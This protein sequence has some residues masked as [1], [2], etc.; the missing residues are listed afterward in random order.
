MLIPYDLKGTGEKSKWYYWGKYAAFTA[1]GV[2]LILAVF[3]VMLLAKCDVSCSVYFHESPLALAVITLVA[4][5][6]LAE[7]ERKTRFA[8]IMRSAVEFDVRTGAAKE[9]TPLVT[10]SGQPSD[11]DI[12][13][14]WRPG[15]VG[16]K[17]AAGAK[18][19]LNPAAT[20]SKVDLKIAGSGAP[21]APKLDAP[22]TP[23]S[24]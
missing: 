11:A 5:I 20:S 12:I 8:E 10:V 13:A 22:T 21:T 7:M 2:F 15:M 9:G 6:I 16:T 24:T 19:P 3:L 4:G 14:G 18:P 23:K 17:L 1:T